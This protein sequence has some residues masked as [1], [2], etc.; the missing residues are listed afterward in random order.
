MQ[1]MQLVHGLRPLALDALG[2]LYP[3]LEPGA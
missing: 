2:A 3:G 1:G